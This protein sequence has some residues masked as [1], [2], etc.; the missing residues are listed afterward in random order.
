MGL[1]SR[2]RADGEGAHHAPKVWYDIE[3]TGGPIDWEEL[4]PPDEPPMTGPR[5][6]AWGRLRNL[7]LRAISHRLG[8]GV[9]ICCYR[10]RMS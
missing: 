6:A 10:V 1:F 7:Q 2:R 4:Y 9:L 5:R 8:P 3:L